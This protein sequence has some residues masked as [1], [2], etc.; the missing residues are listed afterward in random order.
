MIRREYHG[1]RPFPGALPTLT[2]GTKK[3][4]VNLIYVP[5]YE[6]ITEESLFLQLK[7]NVSG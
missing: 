3:A 1:H 2:I 4:A 7:I 6:P 5:G